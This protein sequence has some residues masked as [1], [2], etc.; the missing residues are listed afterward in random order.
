MRPA[1]QPGEGAALTC[2]LDTGHTLGA[3]W[4]D[5]LPGA[6]LESIRAAVNRCFL[7]LVIC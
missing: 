7:L 4:L 5:Q 3:H 6:H 1:G 2:T